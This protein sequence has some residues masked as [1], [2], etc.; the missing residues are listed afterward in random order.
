[1][2]NI[3]TVGPD[4]ALIVSG[5]YKCKRFLCRLLIKYVLSSPGNLFSPNKKTLR[6]GGWIFAWKYLTNVQKISL[7]VMTL[8]PRCKSVETAQG[9]PLTVTGVAQI[10]VMKNV[11]LLK[12]ASEQFLGKREKDIKDSIIQ[13]LEGHLRAILGTLSVEEV[14][15]DRDQFAALVREVASPDLARMGIDILSFT[16]KDV[17][18]DVSYLGSLGMARTAAVHRDA[19]VRVVQTGRDAGIRE[20]ECKK[21]ASD[22]HYSTET[23]IQNNVKEF[24]LQSASFE[25]EVNIARAKAQLAYQLQEAKTQQRVRQEEIQIKVGKIIFYFLAFVLVN[26]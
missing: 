8:N 4:E 16:I 5:Y 1:M 25:K 24:K 23:N 12:A 22:V 21:A 17:F 18:D 2:G 26:L 9:V 3:H 11:D 10:K 19:E 14:Y 13:T 15:K 20:A 7:R 6:I